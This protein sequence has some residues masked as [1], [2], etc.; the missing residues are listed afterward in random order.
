LSL[1]RVNLENT[2]RLSLLNDDISSFYF[3]KE[4]IEK[5]APK[6]NKFPF[7][8][9]YLVKV[10]LNVDTLYI[11]KSNRKNLLSVQNRILKEYPNILLKE[12]NDSKFNLC[13][14]DRCF[15]ASDSID[16][17]LESVN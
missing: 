6:L 12:T 16:E 7:N 11:L 15:R 13:S 9:P 14:I 8:Y 1:L 5:F 3:A 17:V 10:V 2:L 4:E